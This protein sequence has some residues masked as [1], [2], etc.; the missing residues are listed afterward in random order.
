MNCV[1]YLR[2]VATTPHKFLITED[3]NIHVHN[4]LDTKTIAFLSVLS[5]A[6][7]IQH[8][9]FPTQCSR[10]YISDLVITSTDSSLNI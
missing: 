9:S 2:P 1:L 5:D 4:S 10:N 8:V 3:V 6:N 7:I